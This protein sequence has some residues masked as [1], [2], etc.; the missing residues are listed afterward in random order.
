MP[1]P[2]T[3]TIPI[4][5][6]NFVN[7]SEENGFV[8]AGGNEAGATVNLCLAGGSG[9]GGACG[10]G[11]GRTLRTTVM[12]TP[13]SSS[14]TGW[15]YSVTAVDITAMEEGNETLTATATDAVGNISDPA[16]ADITVDTEVPSFDSGLTNTDSVVVNMADYSYNANAT[17]NGL[18]GETVDMG[19]TYALAVADTVLFDIVAETGVVTF[20]TPPTTDDIPTYTITITAADA[21]GNTATQE[22][23]IN[24]LVTPTVTIT[25]NIEF[26]TIANIADGILTFT[27]TFNE[28]VSEFVLTDI[29]VDSD[30][31]TG[32]LVGIAPTDIYTLEVTLPTTNGGMLTVAV[33]ADTVVGHTTGLRNLVGA[34]YMQGYDTMAPNIPGFDTVGDLNAASLDTGLDIS[35][36][37][38]DGATVI[39]CLAGDVTGDGTGVSC[40][41]SSEERTIRDQQAGGGSAC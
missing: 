30:V 25:N 28:P 35:G 14:N 9:S 38:E 8:I 1:D 26:D 32:V 41:E 19:I 3:F 5:I 27:F 12:D 16:S 7:A 18:E 10:I 24:V 15:S 29:T 33:A 31:S 40:G 4:A 22:V 36:I 6:D 13:G 39:L 23:T 37:N 2:P 21:A 20:K 17:D 34:T 11:I